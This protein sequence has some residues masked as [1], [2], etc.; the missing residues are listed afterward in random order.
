MKTTMGVFVFC[1]AT[2]LAAAQDYTPA[3]L[4]V[5][6]YVNAGTSSLVQGMGMDMNMYRSGYGGMYGNNMTMYNYT[7]SFGGGVSLTVPLHPRWSFV[8]NVGYMNR[9]ANY[10]TMN[11]STYNSRY[12]LSYIDVWA[13][14]QYNNIPKG[15]VK[16]TASWGLTES[17]LISAND[18][19]PTGYT[20]MMSNV[21]RIDIGMV[22]GPGLEF[23]LKKKG[24]IQAK[25]LYTFGF[26]NV[27]QGMYYD[28][29][30]RSNNAGFLLQV[31]HFF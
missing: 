17:T 11:S 8:G 7:G 13:L 5:G 29:G 3:K 2:T 9:G 6:L 27:F 18:E 22:L 23:G 20:G 10:G 19:T 26:M 15:P 4:R 21:N 24:A 30:M 31:G 1:L 25:L 16:F 14:G 12:R 28:N